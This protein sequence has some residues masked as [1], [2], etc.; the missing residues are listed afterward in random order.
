MSEILPTYNYSDL[1]QS[2]LTA[3]FDQINLNEYVIMP[4]S[5]MVNSVIWDLIV[6]K[7][8]NRASELNA[9]INW[10]EEF[11]SD[12]SGERKMKIWFTKQ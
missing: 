3:D 12:T 1:P 6:E 10:I 4:V 2:G 5:L 7:I 8:K 11:N 9:D